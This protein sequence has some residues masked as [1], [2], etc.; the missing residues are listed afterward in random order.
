ME[1][2][3]FDTIFSVLFPIITGIMAIFFFGTGLRAI[4]TKRPFLVFNRWMLSM[5]FVAL[6]PGI[7]L[8]L[9]SFS[10]D[11]MGWTLPL[12]YGVILV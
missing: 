1:R 2:D 7:V 11:I 9:K 10:G 8:S 4:L 5:I 3:Y 6:V 12:L